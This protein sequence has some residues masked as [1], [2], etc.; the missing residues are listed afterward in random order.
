MWP[1]YMDS[2]RE[3]KLEWRLRGNKLLTA[4]IPIVLASHASWLSGT[5][6]S[7]YLK[8]R[9]CHKYKETLQGNPKLR[10]RDWHVPP[11]NWL[12][13]P[14]WEASPLEKTHF[15]TPLLIC[16][17]EPLQYSMFAFT[18]CTSHTLLLPSLKSIVQPE[19]R[20]VERSRVLPLNPLGFVH[21]RQCF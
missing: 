3:S 12:R 6:K 1:S 15:R 10:S 14:L 13:P 2:H 16:Y 20:G 19:K 8:S 4:F 7:V 5:C 17:S 18:S 9:R 11:G 21:N